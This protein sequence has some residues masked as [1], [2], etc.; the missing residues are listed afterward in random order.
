MGGGDEGELDGGGT[1]KTFGATPS[2]VVILFDRIKFGNR[3]IIILI[4]T[5]NENE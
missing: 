2:W 4:F 1:G 3:I 5:P